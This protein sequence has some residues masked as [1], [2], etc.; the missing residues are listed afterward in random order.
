MQSYQEPRYQAPHNTHSHIELTEV[1]QPEQYGVI[2]LQKPLKLAIQGAQLYS[3][4]KKKDHG[5]LL[6]HMV[7]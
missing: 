1:P 2:N 5:I 7:L 6:Y 4:K 3:E